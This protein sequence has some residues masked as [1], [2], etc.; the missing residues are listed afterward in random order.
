MK[1]SIIV[2]LLDS[3]D[4]E[5]YL[6]GKSKEY[7]MAIATCGE[8]EIKLKKALDKESELIFNEYVENIFKCLNL[9]QESYFRDGFIIGARIM[10]EVLGK[11][12]KEQE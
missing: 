11:E 9:D 1:E 12:D 4:M 3:V 5:E 10:L 7:E 6:S 2:K 8:C